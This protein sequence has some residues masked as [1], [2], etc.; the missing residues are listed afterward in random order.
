MCRFFRNQAWI[1]RRKDRLFRREGWFFPSDFCALYLVIK[2]YIHRVTFSA[3]TK[4]I[5]CYLL[6]GENCFSKNISPS[7]TTTKYSCYRPYYGQYIALHVLEL[8]LRY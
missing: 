2:S 3:T 7:G 6:F 8:V 4:S 5:V 1:F